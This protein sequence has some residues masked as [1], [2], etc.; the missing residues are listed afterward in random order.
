MEIIKTPIEGLLVIRPKIFGDDRGHF[1]ESWSKES[2]TKNGMDLDFVQDN[3]SLSSKGVLR[4]LHF[5]NPPFAQ[6]KL[7]RVIKGI[8]LDVAVDIR[9]D[10]PTYGQHFSIKLSEKNKTIFWIPPGFAHGF[11]T[12]EDDTIFTYKC[13]GVYNKESEGALLWSDKD[14]N[15][16]WGVENPLVSDKDLVAGNFINFESQF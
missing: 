9:K 5:Q 15:I 3:Q 13:T 14:L 16:D 11:V 8:V 7:V 1:F 10:S 6:G 12:L 4:G 2:F